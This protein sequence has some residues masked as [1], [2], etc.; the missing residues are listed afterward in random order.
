MVRQDKKVLVESQVSQS[1]HPSASHV[2]RIAPPLLPPLPSLL[3]PPSSSY[4]CRPLALARHLTLFAT[5]AWLPN[6]MIKTG[7]KFELQNSRHRPNCNLFWQVAAWRDDLESLRTLLTWGARSFAAS[8]FF[9]TCELANMHSYHWWLDILS[10]TLLVGNTC[11]IVIVIVFANC[12]DA[13]N[14]RKKW[15]KWVI[16]TNQ[17][18]LLEHCHFKRL[19]AKPNILRLWRTEFSLYHIMLMLF[20]IF[21]SLPLLIRSLLWCC[22]S[23]HSFDTLIELRE[24]FK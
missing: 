18:T 4:F 23:Y 9:A 2:V 13:I 14:C 7:E 8:I 19:R 6:N 22:F 24:G 11:L 1:P 21:I 17:T 20:A 10:T 12:K 5:Y 3:L 15:W 16:L